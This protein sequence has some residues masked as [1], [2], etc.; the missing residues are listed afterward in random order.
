MEVF[1]FFHLALALWATLKRQPSLGERNLGL[2][3]QWLMYQVINFSLSFHMTSQ[4]RFYNCYYVKVTLA[5][6]APGHTFQGAITFQQATTHW[7]TWWTTWAKATACIPAVRDQFRYGIWWTWQCSSFQQRQ[8]RRSVLCSSNNRQSSKWFSS[9]KFSFKAKQLLLRQGWA[10]TTAT[11]KN[12]TA[13]LS[14]ISTQLYIAWEGRCQDGMEITML[15][16]EG[17][18]Y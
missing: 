7:N 3:S 8:T 6:T 16:G 15:S 5:H 2:I 10:Q 17:Y 1:W 12:P 18:C 13:W 9:H 4:N 11:H 14:W